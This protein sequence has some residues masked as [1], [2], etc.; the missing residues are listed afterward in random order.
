MRKFLSSLLAMSCAAGCGPTPTPASTVEE[1]A[2]ETPAAAA[3]EIPLALEPMPGVPGYA[4]SLMNKAISEAGLSEIATCL[5]NA[6]I[7]SGRYEAPAGVQILGWAWDTAAVAPYSDFLVVN[8]AKVVAGFGMG[9]TSRPD[10]PQANPDI[11]TAAVGYTAY[12]TGGPGSYVVLGYS[13]AA[14]TVCPVGTI[15]AP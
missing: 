9:G 4:A 6:D 12:V 2:V 15:A 10:V 11:P 13:A 7:V 5:G 14:K 1:P 8:D 3:P